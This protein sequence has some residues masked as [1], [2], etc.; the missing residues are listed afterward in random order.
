MG[1]DSSGLFQAILKIVYCRHEAYN[2]LVPTNHSEFLSSRLRLS[3]S[4]RN[5]DLRIEFDVALAISDLSA[6]GEFVVFMGF[7]I[8]DM[9]TRISNGL[10]RLFIL[11][12][13]LTD[14]QKYSFDCHII[15]LT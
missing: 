14:A 8:E 5:F 13:F 12:R 3:L 4:Y 11:K 1:F 15:I 10:A 6:N 2:N 7:G 9:K